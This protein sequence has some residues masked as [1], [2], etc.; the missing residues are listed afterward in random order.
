MPGRGTNSVVVLLGAGA[1][2][3]AGLRLSTELTT[4]LQSDLVDS[5]DSLL[6]RTLGLILG[7]LAFRRGYEGK[8]MHAPVD[9]ESVLAIAQ[10]LSRRSEHPLCSF[11]ATWHSFLEEIG[12]KG[13]GT[14]FEALI[15]RARGMLRTKLETPSDGTIVKYLES[16]CRLSEGLAD[17]KSPEVFTLN[18]DRCVESALQYQRRRFTTGFRDGMW[19]RDEFAVDGQVRLYKLHGSFG[20]VRHPESDVLYDRDGAMAR[21]DL[22]IL[23]AD[24][25][26][27]LIFGAD[28]KFSPRQPYLWMIYRFVE[29]LER[30]SYIVT[31]GYGFRDVH[32]NQALTQAMAADP[33]KHLLVVG[34]GLTSADID[35]RCESRYYPERTTFIEEGAKKA[36]F[37]H[38]TILKKLRE[39][40]KARPK[41]TPFR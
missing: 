19:N 12:P 7:A 15:R 35:G 14:A 25:E 20:W 1:S 27:D 36:L 37:E 24:T 5:K 3:D 18:Y 34:P 31:I 2:K 39:L 41:A 17:D 13:N 11:V 33:H 22:D 30:C 32:I 40:E 26:D 38:D 4:D 16:A 21:D 23:S 29:A 28:N 10:M 8:T 9:I 6:Q